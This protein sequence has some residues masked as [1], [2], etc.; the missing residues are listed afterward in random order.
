MIDNKRNKQNPKD[1]RYIKKKKTETE[2]KRQKQQ[3][4][5]F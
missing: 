2:I 5:C 3:Q 1:R 4:R